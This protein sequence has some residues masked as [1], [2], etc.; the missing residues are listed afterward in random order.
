MAYRRVASRQLPVPRPA[1]APLG[2]VSLGSVVSA[3]PL[4]GLFVVSAYF[5]SRD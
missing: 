1:A 2:A 4:L 5:A 3:L